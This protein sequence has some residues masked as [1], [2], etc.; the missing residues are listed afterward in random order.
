MKKR[1]SPLSI[2]VLASL[3]VF[4]G[5]TVFLYTSDTFERNKPTILVDEL[6]YWNLKEPISVN[7]NDSSGI[8]FARITLSDGENSIALVNEKY[9]SKENDKVFSLSFPKTGFFS[10]K[11]EYTL[12]IEVVD[13]SKWN[14]F[15][16]NMAKK[17]V[18]VVIDTKRPNVHIV[19]NSYKITKGGVA[20]VIFKAEDNNMQDIY[21]QTNS[22]KTFSVTPF[23]QEGYYISLIAW[24]IEDKDFSAHIIAKDLAGNIAKE[25]IRY[26]LDSRNY[27]TSKIKLSDSFL[28]DKVSSLAED[29]A[30]EQTHTL[31]PLDKFKF[32]NSELRDASVDAIQ[33][34]TSKI[35]YDNGFILKTFNPLKNGA[36]VA[37]YGDFRIYEYNKEKVSESYHLGLDLASTKEADIVLSNKG[38]VVFAD[39]NGIYGKT[40]IVYHG[41]GIYSLYAHCS[42]VFV[43]VEDE[44][45]AGDVIAKTGKTGFVFGDHLHFGMIVQGVEVRPAEWMDEKWMDENIFGLIKNS[46]KMVEK[47]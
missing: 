18:K 44:V 8:K 47:Y 33:K 11:N 24:P 6:V 9:E 12:D 10:K 40:V 28:E 27:K 3:I 20:T 25:R 30:Y 21:I 13:Y 43:S 34:T 16:G 17:S 35:D 23:Y 42:Q 19:N 38:V 7:I 15:S 5:V 26:Y 22:G 4:F 41:L 45:L 29:I 2:A 14:F 46:K 1:K 37:S 31:S 32:I 36:A 39:D